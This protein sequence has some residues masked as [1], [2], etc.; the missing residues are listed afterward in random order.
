MNADALGTLPGERRGT[1]RRKHRED[2]ATRGK[3]RVQGEENDHDASLH[4]LSRRGAGAV[5]AG[6]AG[7][8]FRP[9]ATTSGHTLS[10]PRRPDRDFIAL[11]DGTEA[12]RSG[13]CSY[14][15]KNAR[16]LL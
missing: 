9:A 10:A 1:K 13:P 11:S 3:N 14:E 5:V 16:P 6:E 8:P 12:L 15:Q 7:K 4:A 2:D